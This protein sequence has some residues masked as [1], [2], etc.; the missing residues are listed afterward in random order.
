MPVLNKLHNLSLRILTLCG[1]G[2]VISL[3]V[4]ILTAVLMFVTERRQKHTDE[5]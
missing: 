2:A 3:A 1:I 4:N 5:Q